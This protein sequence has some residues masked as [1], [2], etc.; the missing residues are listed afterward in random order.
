MGKTF[1]EK[2]LAKKAGLKEVRPG[3]IVTVRPD[4]LL[5][6]DNTAAIVEKITGDLAEFGVCSRELHVVVLDH[7]VPAASEKDAAN[8]VFL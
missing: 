4:H 5:S 1:A 8:Q 2:V 3:Q 6:H 7:V